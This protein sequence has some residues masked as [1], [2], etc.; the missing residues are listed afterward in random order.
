MIPQ[1]TEQI[2]P[3]LTR[4]RPEMAKDLADV[5]KQLRPEFDKKADDMIN[6]AAHVYAR[7]MSEDE[8]KQTAAFFNSPV[9]K[10]YVDSQPAMLDELVVAMQ[11][12]TQEI[13][14][15]MMTRVRQEMMKKGH[16][17]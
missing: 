10:K 11:S 14:T 6:I 13:S 9:G 4:T 7:K 16:Q 3:M 8:L 2:G 5:L 17:F 12:W 1:L 15:Y